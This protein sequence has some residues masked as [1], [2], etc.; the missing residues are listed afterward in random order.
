MFG[1]PVE[2]GSWNSMADA[3]YYAGH[4]GG[5]ATWLIISIVLC[6]VALFVGARHE[7]KSYKEKDD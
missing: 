2:D 4:G 7:S 5:E 6:V 3:A 1:S